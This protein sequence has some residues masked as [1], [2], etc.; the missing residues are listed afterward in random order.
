MGARTGFEEAAA[1][2][3]HA[4]NPCSGQRVWTNW[5][6]DEGWE[7]PMGSFEASPAQGAHMGLQRGGFFG[8]H[9]CETGEEQPVDL[10][11]FERTVEPAQ[12]QMSGVDQGCLGERHSERKLKTRHSGCSEAKKS[13]FDF[14]ATG[15]NVLG[16]DEQAGLWFGGNLMLAPSCARA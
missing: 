9:G 14:A 16:D 3:I 6:R 15:G 8:A 2:E 7:G 10:F 13:T 1:S 12:Q 4:L 11:L 5:L